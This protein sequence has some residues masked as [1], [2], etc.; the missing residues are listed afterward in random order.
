MMRKPYTSEDSQQVRLR[1]HS[2]M[3]RLLKS[4]IEPSAVTL[5]G[6]KHAIAQLKQY[7]LSDEMCMEAASH[8]LLDAVLGIGIHPDQLAAQMFASGRLERSK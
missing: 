7:D 4:G 6:Y 8:M 5:E 2:F 3:G 1:M